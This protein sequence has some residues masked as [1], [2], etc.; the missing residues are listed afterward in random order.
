MASLACPASRSLSRGRV[1]APG[2][3]FDRELSEEALLHSVRLARS[4]RWLIQRPTHVTVIPS[5][6]PRAGVAQLAERQPS[7]LHVAGSIPVS[8]SNFPGSPRLVDATPTG[9]LWCAP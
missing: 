8:R 4:G 9:P 2:S 7:K 6:I 5:P 1:S 3:A